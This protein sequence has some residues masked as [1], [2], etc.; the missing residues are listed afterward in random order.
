MKN[1][2]M[3]WDGV[4]FEDLAE[5]SNQELVCGHINFDVNIL[6]LLRRNAKQIV[7]YINEECTG[8][9]YLTVISI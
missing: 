9:S 1:A 8:I 3:Y 7:G 2:A 4:G 6:R 5:E